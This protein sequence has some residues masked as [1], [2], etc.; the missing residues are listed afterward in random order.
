[1]FFIN[2]HILVERNCVRITPPSSSPTLI[3]V[4]LSIPEKDSAATISPSLPRA[5]TTASSNVISRYGANRPPVVSKK[6]FSNPS[7]SITSTA[8]TEV[9]IIDIQLME[10]YN[11]ISCALNP[12]ES[13]PFQIKLNWAYKSQ[14]K[15]C[16]PFHI[17]R[18][19]F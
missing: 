5:S 17:V 8:V 9:P 18:L 2:P 10:R 19:H 14:I 13:L 1:M 3:T 4:D 7:V 16:L 11:I 15:L 6:K 12:L